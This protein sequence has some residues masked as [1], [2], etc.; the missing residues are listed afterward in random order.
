MKQGW[1]YKKLGEVS[2]F[3]NGF[4]FKSNL[5]RKDGCPI[6]RISNI[7]NEEIF[8]DDIVYFNKEDY[9]VNFDNY[10]ILPNDIL[11]AM[12]GG[13]TGKLGINTTNTIFYQNQRVGVI[14]EDKQSLNHRYLFYFLHTKSE[15]SLKIAAGAAQPN[16]STAQIKNFIIPIPPLSE[17]Q[18]IVER[19]DAAFAHIDELKANA[20]KQVNEA[21]A[22]F[23]KALEKAMEPKE[24]WGEKKIKDVIENLR[25]GLNP[26]VHFKLNTEDATGYYIT[27]RELKGF[28]FEVDNKTDRINDAA[29]K[30]INER[31]NLLIGDVLYSGTGTIGRTAVVKELPTWWGIKEGVYAITP[32]KSLLDSLFLVYVLHSDSFIRKVMAKTSG[33]TVRSI[34]M[35]E[36]KEVTIP[37]PP[38]TTQHHIVARLDSLSENVKKLEEI[39]RKIIA[40]CDA[41]KQALL[42]KVF[43]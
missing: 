21:R 17:Q 32:Q 28:N 18:R 24:G 40:E 41:L 39:Q 34:P 33:T 16:L 8:T 14:R 12:S 27:V 36:L 23:Q 37:I 10:K 3:Q 30:R 38:L 1:T 9:P 19:L 26:R 2:S 6:V 42:R 25:T 43:E 20:E 22:L 29:I 35:K 15:E 31:S 13:T 4:A 5:F 7:Q 11:I